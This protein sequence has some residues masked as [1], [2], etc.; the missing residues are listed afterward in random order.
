LPFKTPT[1]IIVTGLDNKSSFSKYGP[2]CAPDL[3]ANERFYKSLDGP[4]WLMNFTDYGHADNLNGLFR[5]VAGIMC[6]SCGL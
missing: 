2:S 4:T 3:I 5:L 1:L 6:S